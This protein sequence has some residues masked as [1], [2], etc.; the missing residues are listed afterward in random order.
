MRKMK[1]KLS[2]FDKMFS[3]TIEVES[4]E[5]YIGARICVVSPT[6]TSK[7]EYRGKKEKGIPILEYVGHRE[8]DL[9]NY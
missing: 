5:L 7:F 9:T 3:K 4:K 2:V 8:H 6:M 1:V